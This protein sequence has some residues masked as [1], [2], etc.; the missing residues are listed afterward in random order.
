[1]T[2]T[3]GLL[4]HFLAALAYRTPKALRGT[5]SPEAPGFTT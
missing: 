3:P 1:M 5:V 4:P 2:I